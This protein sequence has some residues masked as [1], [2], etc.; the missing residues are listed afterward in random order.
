MFREKA[1]WLV[2]SNHSV[3]G[4]KKKYCNELVDDVNKG[5]VSGLKHIISNIIL[6]KI[7]ISCTYE[8]KK[9]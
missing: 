5:I 6:L 4:K 9:R 8:Q 2:H 7:L 3:R 1:Q